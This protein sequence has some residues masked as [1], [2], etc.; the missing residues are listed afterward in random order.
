MIN[1]HLLQSEGDLKNLLKN[2]LSVLLYIDT[3]A[4]SA[5]LCLFL[6]KVLARGNTLYGHKQELYKNHISPERNIKA[7]S[8]SKV[9]LY[10][11]NQRLLLHCCRS[12][13]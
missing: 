2:I 11:I 1:L 4:I 3:T 13:M 10:K 6:L 8:Y 5:F 12:S 9:V 7:K